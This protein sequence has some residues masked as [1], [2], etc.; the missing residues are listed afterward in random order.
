MWLCV[1]MLSHMSEADSGLQPVVMCLLHPSND[2]RDEAA[3]LLQ[4]IDST[5]V[6][7]LA[8]AVLFCFVWF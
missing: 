8:F 6:R 5:H 3:R 4:R 2:V 1:Q 7:T